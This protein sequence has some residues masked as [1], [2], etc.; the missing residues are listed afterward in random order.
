MQPRLRV[1]M[2][3]KM[4]EREQEQEQERIQGLA[5]AAVVEADQEVAQILLEP[6]QQ[7]GPEQA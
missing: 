5:R 7:A 2:A 6:A 1:E 4:Q 3:E